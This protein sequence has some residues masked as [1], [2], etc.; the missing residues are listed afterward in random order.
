MPDTLVHIGRIETPWARVEDCPRNIQPEG[1]PCRLLVEPKYL[2]ALEGLAAGDLIL[3]LYWLGEADRER[4][5]GRS[6]RTGRPAGAF[7][8]RTPHRPNPIGAAVLRI[9]AIEGGAITVRGL[10][11]VS[12]TALLDIKPAMEPELPAPG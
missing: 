9:E 3:V 12:G 4:L 1:P 10:D 11:C 5:V 6:R 8:R 7:A 2:P